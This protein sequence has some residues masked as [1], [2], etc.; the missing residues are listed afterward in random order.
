ML[1]QLDIFFRI[2]NTVLL[3][4]LALILIR[5]HPQRPS[6]ILGAVLAIGAA[7][8]G[9]FEYTLGWGSVALEIP[10][11][12][13]C[14]AAPVAF[15]LL[16]KALF[17]DTFQWKWSYLLVYAVFAGSGLF[18]HYITFGDLRGMVHWVLRSDVSHNGLALIPL[19]LMGAILVILAM[20]HALKEWRVDLVESRRH[21]RVA[22]VL[23]AGTTILVITFVE[24]FSLGSPR[25]ILVNTMVSGFFFLIIL[26]I[27]LYFIGF[28]RR[29]PTQQIPHGLHSPS[30]QR[31]GDGIAEKDDTPGDAF[32]EELER[33]MVEKRLFC[34][35]GL[36]IGRLAER[37]EMKEY[38]LRRMINGHLG[39]RNYN[40]FLNRYRI[41]EAA[42][43]LLA[44]ETRHLPV[45][46]IALDVG[47]RSLTVFNKAFKEIMNMTPTEFRNQH[48]HEIPL[49]N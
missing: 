15:W 4:L 16:S 28:Y 42:K 34:E 27:Y 19:V 47:Y 14:A 2:G 5:D 35:E 44:P 40:Q 31:S 12:L 11:N 26:G 29:H 10:L 8:I 13:M 32:I 3:V 22:G 36:T 33:L 45:L 38:I 49:P 21:A 6:A 48:R 41:E 20:Y 23:L 7:A 18:G 43:L 30:P 46:S 17:E 1:T 25:S 24:F 9:T 39:Y 37:L